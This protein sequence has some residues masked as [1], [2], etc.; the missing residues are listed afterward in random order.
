[1]PARVEFDDIAPFY[2]ETRPAPVPAEL[3]AISDLL[4]ACRT[5]L[6][7]GIG[8]GRFA[9]P[10]SKRGFEMIGIDLS[11]EMMRRAQ[12]K[13]IR[14]LVRA[15]LQR[16]PFQDRS[17]DAA[18]MAHVLQLLP[19][20]WPA[21]RELGRVARRTVVVALPEW[22]EGRGAGDRIRMRSRYREI[23]A[24]LGYSLPQR[25]PRVLPFPRRAQPRG[26][27]SRS[28]LGG[29][30]R[31][32][33]DD[34]GGADRPLGAARLRAVDAPAGSARRGRPSFEGEPSSGRG[35]RDLGAED[36]VRRLGTR[37]SNGRGLVLLR[38]FEPVA[39]TG[40]R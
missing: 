21:L 25:A 40:G 20:P 32:G 22:N 14:S 39:S 15:D 2:D 36:P 35:A 9:V 33:E 16:L 5:V 31:T 7:A 1:M 26:A 38:H 18:F 27:P 6:D 34:P 23:A 24:E 29:A 37:G 19:D 4:G 13:G 10:L 12:G 17:I 3:D 8:T 28:P 30:T 11:I